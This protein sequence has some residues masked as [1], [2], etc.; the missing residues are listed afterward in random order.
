ME[1]SSSNKN[2]KAT[3]LEVVGDPPRVIFCCGGK[4]LAEVCFVV[5]ATTTLPRRKPKHGRHRE[6]KIITLGRRW[7]VE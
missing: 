7:M 2:E 6:L 1:S 5:L 4:T 3:T